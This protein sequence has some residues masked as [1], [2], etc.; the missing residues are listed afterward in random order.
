MEE[1]EGGEAG[2]AAKNHSLST[3]FKE[4]LTVLGTQIQIS[5]L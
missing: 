5:I 1:G 2:A 3:G 4:T